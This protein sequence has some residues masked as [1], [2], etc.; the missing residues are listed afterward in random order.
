MEREALVDNFHRA[1]DVVLCKDRDQLRRGLLEAVEAAKEVQSLA[2]RLIDTHALKF[3]A[4]RQF[5]WCKVERP[6]H[7][8]R[9]H[10][11][12]RRL[13]VWL[14]HVLYTYKPR[15]DGPGERPLLVIVRDHIRG[16]YHCVGASPTHLAEHNDF[17]NRFRAALRADPSLKYRYDFFDK[18]CIEIHA[19]DF[20]TFWRLLESVPA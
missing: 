16:T 3:N 7:L 14:L 1:V 9:H 12:C 20:E 19:D 4:S 11:A 5:R 18:A 15:G 2:R 17:G 10:L 8:F 6:S 13:A